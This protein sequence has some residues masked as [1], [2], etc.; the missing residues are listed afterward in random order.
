M[1]RS[2]ELGWVAEPFHHK[3]RRGVLAAPTPQ[4]YTY[5]CDDNEDTVLT[6]LTNTLRGRYAWRAGLS[7]IRTFRQAA[8]AAKDVGRFTQR[9]LRRQ[10]PLLKDPIALFSAPW[11]HRRFDADVVVMIRHPAAIMWSMKRLNWRFNFNH[12]LRQP[13][14]MRDLLEPWR[15]ELESLAAQPDPDLIE[16][17][18]LV[19][20]VMYGVVDQWRGEFPQWQFVRHEDL[21]RAPVEGF[22]ALFEHA[23][24]EFTDSIVTY[25]ESTT[26]ATNPVSAP[27]G[28]A[29]ALRRDSRANVAAWAAQLDAADVHR[30]RDLTEDVASEWYLDADW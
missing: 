20:R 11:I 2:S 14:L 22:R 1:T 12:L 5:V 24:V 9:R 15:A 4:L 13:L 21:S 3:H 23:Q 29:H 26:H 27:Q 10:R 7:E 19:W 16:E 30:L 28:Q 25:I 6:D 18:A 17:A 8:L